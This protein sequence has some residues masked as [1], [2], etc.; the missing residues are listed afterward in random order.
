MRRFCSPTCGINATNV[1]KKIAAILFTTIL[2]ASCGAGRSTVSSHRTSSVSMQ[3]N[4]V[5]YGRKFLGKPYRYAGRGPNS[6]DCSGFTSF[7]FKEF[8]YTLNPSSGGQ[9]RQFPTVHRKDLKKGDLVFFE[10]SRKNGR[11]G[12]VG[13]VTEARRDGTFRFIHA[14]TNYGVIVSS[15]EEEYYASRYIRGGRVLEED[16]SSP[17]QRKRTTVNVSLEKGETVVSPIAAQRKGRPS[18]K[19]DRSVVLVQTDPLKNPPLKKNHSTHTRNEQGENPLFRTKNDVIL[20]R[21]SADIPEP[22]VVNVE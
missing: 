10:G 20:R 14:S 11:V 8:G 16:D 9:E 5:E 17:G 19:S 7:V 12:H 13:I 21:D 2:L 15:S 3:N 4:V 18:E 22:V 1:Y 6:F